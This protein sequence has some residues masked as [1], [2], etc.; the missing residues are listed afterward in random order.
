MQKS[1][2]V[3]LIEELQEKFRKSNA[4]FVS[5]YQGIKAIEMNDFRKALRNASVDFQVVRNT[6]A[7]R[8]V[9]GTDAEILAADLKGPMAI[10]FSY[11]DAAQAAKALVQ[12][13]KDQPKLKIRFGT[14]GKKAL[15]PEEIK[16]LAELPS[17]EVLIAKLLGTMNAPTT[18]LVGV[19]SGIQRKF[20]YALNAIKDQKAAAQA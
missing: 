1:E 8:A 13:A 19:L 11:K 9:K 5:E 17:R 15:K 18:N 14:L 16:G 20:L 6:L 2:K 7:R 10:A 3:K 4:T 12:Y